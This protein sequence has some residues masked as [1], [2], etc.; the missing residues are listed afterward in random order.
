F[1]DFDKTRE[2]RGERTRDEEA[3]HVLAVLRYLQLHV[4]PAG[5]EALREQAEKTESH[6]EK[7]LDWVESR[8]RE[9]FDLDRMAA[10]C[11]LSTYHV[12]R[13]FKNRVGKTISDYIAARRVREACE[14][15]AGTD[16]TTREIGIEVGALGASYFCEMFKKHKGVTPQAYRAMVRSAY[17][18]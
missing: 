16:K 6:V 5:D 17:E 1:A 9:P 7:M 3:L 8:F 15:L 10:E 11:H 14:L 4:Y 18:R 2:M 12:S 13:L